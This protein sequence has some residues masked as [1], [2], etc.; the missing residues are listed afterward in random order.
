MTQALFTRAL[1]DAAE[2]VPEGLRDGAGRPAGRRFSVYRNNIAVSLTEALETGFPALKSLLGDENFARVAGLYLRA[3]PPGSPILAQYGAGLPA[4]LGTLPQLAHLPYLADVARL[5][6]ALRQSYHAAD[7]SPADPA[8]LAGLDE[9]QLAATRLILAPSAVLLRSRYPVT[10]IHRF[11]TTPGTPTP[12]GGGEDILILRRQFDPVPHV[13]PEGGAA[14]IETLGHAPFGAA[15]E[16]AGDGFDLAAVL[17][18]LM[19]ESA[20]A[21]IH[22]PEIPR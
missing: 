1:F 9:A 4:F 21:H 12:Q 8:R 15:L 5:E 2:P 20:L 22:L 19:S 7:H 6:L 11:A 13:L 17:G 10:Q 3:E 16:A 14:F 18:L